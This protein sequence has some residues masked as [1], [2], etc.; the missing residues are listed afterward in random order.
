MAPFR[1]LIRIRSAVLPLNQSIAN[2]GDLLIDKALAW[3]VHLR[4]NLFFNLIL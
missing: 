2:I 1:G 4:D 3:D